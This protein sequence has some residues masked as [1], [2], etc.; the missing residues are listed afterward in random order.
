MSTAA[1]M[2]MGQPCSQQGWAVGAAFCRSSI[3]R[4]F[5]TWLHAR[6]QCLAPRLHRMPSQLLPLP[7]LLPRHALAAVRLDGFTGLHDELY[8]DDYAAEEVI[9]EVL[10]AMAYGRARSSASWTASGLRALETGLRA[11]AQ[12]RRGL[13]SDPGMSAT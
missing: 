1:L 5:K 2:R 9:S 11:V 13:T 6:A 8:I 4:S 3:P 7:L 12:V 10:Q